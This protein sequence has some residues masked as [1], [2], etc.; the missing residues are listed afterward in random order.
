MSAVTQTRAFPP[1]PVN[2]RE[3]LRY[4]GC[5]APDARLDALLD[6][7]LREVQSAPLQ[8]GV[9]FC[10]LPLRLSGET[11]D[12][13]A[14]SCRSAQLAACLRDCDGVVIFAATVGVGIDRLIAKYSR[15]SPA[16]AVLLQAVGAERIEALCD[17]FCETLPAETQRRTR[18]RFSPGYGDLPLTVQRDIMQTLD[19]A[20]RIGLTLNESLLLSP[21]KSV[22]AFVGLECAGQAR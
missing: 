13:G 10:R 15:L 11:C 19:C 22:T 3:I 21:T 6:D 9:C 20:R 2:R 8:Y 17:R 1:P 12:F 14:F 4:A 5:A 18:P 16:R 7:C